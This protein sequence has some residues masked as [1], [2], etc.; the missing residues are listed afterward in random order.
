MYNSKTSTTYSYTNK[1]DLEA[2]IFDCYGTLFDE[3]SIFE[4]SFS[5]IS[6]DAGI[7]QEKLE[8]SFNIN[9][10]IINQHLKHQFFMTQRQ[11][12][13]LV[14]DLTLSNLQVKYSTQKAV[15]RLMNEFA[16]VETF[17]QAREIVGN[18]RKK[19][20]VGLLANGDN[21]CIFKLMRNSG[22]EFGG[23]ITSENVKAYK[24]D[25]VIFQA[26]LSELRV[27]PEKAVMIGN[28]AEK[29]ILG[30]LNQGLKVIWLNSDY[31]T[32]WKALYPDIEEPLS[33]RKLS[34]LLLLLL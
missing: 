22:L 32:A 16:T 3:A 30:A 28:D 12:Y 23:I 25:P 18:L 10:R 21:D 5:Y 14:F 26:I 13:S 11:R 29:D 6:E 7:D 33:I 34:E 8:Q 17:P 20:K 27:A 9:R 19:H 1:P 4:N 31:A 2:V 15:E 24:P